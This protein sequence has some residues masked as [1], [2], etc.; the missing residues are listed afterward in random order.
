MLEQLFGSKTRVKVMKVF[1]ENPEKRFFV[2]ELTR[3]TDSLINS[4][5]RELA[6]LV[7]VG[8]L[9]IDDVAREQ[10]NESSTAT[11]GLN[12]KK[13][14][15]LN[16][17]NMF[18]KEFDALFSKGQFM[19]EKKFTDQILKHGEIRYMALSGVFIDKSNTPTDMIVIGNK[20]NKQKIIE[21]LKKFE[22]KIDREIR[23]TLMDMREFK[24]RKDIA[25]RFLN[26][27]INDE[28]SIV[29]VNELDL[30]DEI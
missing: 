9:V 20:L 3:L 1:L 13:Y 8:F 18:L 19:L 30:I 10:E 27:I 4:V 15:R 22:Q 14:F 2:R 5:R 28:D 7:E 25:D 12:K 11:R 26:D 16:K 23:Y 21:V 24:L 29:L 17:G 6:N